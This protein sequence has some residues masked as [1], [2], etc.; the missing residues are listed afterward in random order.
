MRYIEGN[1][2]YQKMLFPDV[3]DEYISEENPVRVIDAYIDRLKLHELDFKLRNNET[4]RPS[5]NPKD[6]LKL[7]VYGCFNRIRS[8]RRLET[9][10]QRNIEVMWLLNKLSPDHKTIARFRKDNRKA[11]KNVF[12]DFV[13]LCVKL[14]LYGKELIAVDGS[15]FKAVN[16]L[17][18]NFGHKKLDDRIKRIDEKLEQY[19]A[20]L[21][22]NDQDD[23]D[24]PK[25]TKAEISAMISELSARK[26]GYEEIRAHLNETG[27]TQISTTDP[28]AKRMNHS[29]GL[30]E[31]CYN[32]QTAC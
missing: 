8:S 3:I 29:N 1:D 24:A 19:L 13:K 22:K 18:N 20:E 32:I 16:A 9:E 6:M 2:R 17:E 12:R 28:D 23:M 14:G 31:L 11:L 7:Y 5:Y 27:Q 25:H 15:K 10:T 26:Q 21:D 30:S 4:G